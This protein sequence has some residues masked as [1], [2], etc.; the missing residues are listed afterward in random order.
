MELGR[1]DPGRPRISAI[2]LSQRYGELFQEVKDAFLSM[3][4]TQLT[5]LLDEY[6]QSYGNESADYATKTIHKWRTGRV[7]MTGETM[8]R[9]L[10][11]VPR[12]LAMPQKL[13]L[14]KRLRELAY[15]R[16][17]KVNV[18]LSLPADRPIESTLSAVSKL[19]VQ[20]VN[21]AVPEGLTEIQSWLYA[22]DTVALQ[23]ML[24]EQEREMLYALVADLYWNIQLGRWIRTHTPGRLVV[25]VTFEIPTAHVKIEIR[26][27]GRLRR[28]EA[29]TLSNPDQDV[30][31]QIVRAESDSRFAEGQITAQEY[32]LR[33]IDRYFTA[34]Q[35]EELRLIAAKQGL[36]LDKMK[37]EVMLRGQT[38]E[39]DIEQFK[40]L[41]EDLKK[42]GAKA[43]VEGN[44]QT[45]SGSVLIK[46]KT[47]PL[48]C[49]GL[50]LALFVVA[51]LLVAL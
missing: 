24:V 42:S 15:R 12:H 49:L 23:Q 2:E 18:N 21:L 3:P 32:I 43:D 14:V 38:S 40:T 35:Q 11:L 48:G 17:K 6:R 44:Y 27:P 20:Q 34:A 25:E 13:E 41:L 5:L 16:Q 33:N 39:H 37:T 26:R 29:P 4:Y 30:I 45:P 19:V 7:R 1:G 47:R 10:D 22:N 9:L 31:T 28:G 46:A 51:L 50:A 36:E 8:A